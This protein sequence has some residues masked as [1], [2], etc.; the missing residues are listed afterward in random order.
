[1]SVSPSSGSGD[2]QA[3]T[4]VFS[5]GN[6]FADL[7]FVYVLINQYLTWQG[8][9][10]LRYDRVANKLEMIND[11][12]STWQTGL[13]PGSGTISNSMCS[14][15][16]SGVAV[17]SSGN[18]LSVSFPVTFQ[19]GFTGTKNVWLN[20]V[21]QG[22]AAANWQ[23]GG[24]WTVPSGGGGGSSPV[25]PTSVSITPS[26][27]SG[28]SQTFTMTHSDGNGA[29]DLV[30]TYWLMNSSLTWPGSCGLRYDRSANK[31]QIINDQGMAWQTGITPGSGTLSNSY[32][33]IQGS[34]VSVSVSGNNVSVTFPVAFKAGFKGTKSIYLNAMD[35]RSAVSEWQYRGSWTVP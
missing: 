32:C 22:G 31:L 21:D 12:G 11:Q 27:G 2:S 35:A 34:G 18:T 14:V 13:T 9:C 1:V 15:T 26:A 6:G 3:F 10:G 20:A 25:A 16:G 24:T 29:S 19:S 28:T 8:S 33:T 5:D 17:N 4:A 30:Y 7:R 23:F